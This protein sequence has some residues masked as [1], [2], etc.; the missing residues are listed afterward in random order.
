MARHG[1]RLAEP[2][3]NGGK[4]TKA[5]WRVHEW[6]ADC[7]ISRAFTYNLLRSGAIKSVKVG[8]ARIITTT[9]AEFLASLAA[10][11]S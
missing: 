6:A 3:M 4:P 2:T 10:E 8:A 7:G 5:G 1:N 9:P 11:V